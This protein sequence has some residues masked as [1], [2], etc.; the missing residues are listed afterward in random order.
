VLTHRAALVEDPSGEARVVLL[1]AQDHLT[2]RPPFDVQCAVPSGEL[3]KRR[4]QPNL[5]HG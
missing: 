2:E 3:S 5:G 1:E 4:S